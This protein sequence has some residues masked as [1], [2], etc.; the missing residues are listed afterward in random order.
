[1]GNESDV[2][3]GTGALYALQ[4]RSDNESGKHLIVQKLVRRQET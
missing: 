4:V 3:V 1:M 2:E